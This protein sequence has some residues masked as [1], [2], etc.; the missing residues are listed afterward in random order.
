MVF[1]IILGVFYH[2]ISD[3]TIEQKINSFQIYYQQIKLHPARKNLREKIAPRAK[4]FEE[5]SFQTTVSKKT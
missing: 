2:K 1:L 4:Q 3:T 5:K